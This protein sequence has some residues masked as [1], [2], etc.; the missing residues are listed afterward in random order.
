M[1]S[2]HDREGIRRPRL[3]PDG[4]AARQAREALRAAALRANLRRRKADLTRRK[5]H[6][7]DHSDDDDKV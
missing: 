1:A 3:T 6:Q 4:A 2:K 5:S 7:A